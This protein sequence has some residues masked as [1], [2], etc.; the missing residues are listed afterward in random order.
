MKIS[1]KA[2][3]NSDAARNTKQMLRSFPA[4]SS[5]IFQFSSTIWSPVPI[6][7]AG[8]GISVLP[9]Q[10]REKF[11][12]HRCGTGYCI[13]PSI[14]HCTRILTAALFSIRTHVASIR[15]RTAPC[16]D[17]E[18]PSAPKVAMT[19]ERFGRY[20]AILRNALRP[21]TTQYSKQCWR[22]ISCARA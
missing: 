19:P 11:I 9:T 17:S 5:T 13:M 6:G 3:R 18:R 10:N 8:T 4:T 15:E 7:T 21:L 22:G 2:G 16:G 20:R 14:A 12:R 1:C